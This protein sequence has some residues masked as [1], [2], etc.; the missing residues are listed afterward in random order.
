MDKIGDR[1]GRLTILSFTASGGKKRCLF[2][3]D[4]GEQI[5][6]RLDSAKS[7]DYPSCGC[8]GKEIRKEKTSDRFD[9][10]P[11]VGY[12]FGRLLVTGIDSCI[13]R[14]KSI[15]RLVCLCDCGAQVVVRGDQLKSGVTKSCGCIQK[16][17]A[18]SSR[19]K[20]IN[21]T[22][23]NT[24]IGTIGKGQTSI[25]ASWLKI[26]DL[27]LKDRGFSYEKVCHEYD[28]RWD[29]FEEFLSDFGQIRNDQ[30]I[31]RHDNKMPWY[32]ENCFIN[33]G[34]RV[35]Q[36]TSDSAIK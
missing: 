23:A 34:K 9:F 18:T 36:L 21:T 26:K 16:E 30:T 1:Y 10:M 31:S 17:W 5:T 8:W 7:K 29:D 20:E 13:S 2:K 15:S 19:L 11:Y 32:K 25:Y 3:C 4:C 27:C 35:L 12:K 14:K 6:M 24:T 28:P 33:I 22:H